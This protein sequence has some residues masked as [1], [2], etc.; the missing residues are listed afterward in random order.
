MDIGKKTPSSGKSENNGGVSNEGRTS[1]RHTIGG[2]P[3][4]N[5]IEP[6]GSGLAAQKSESDR[7]KEG[8]NREKWSDGF[9]KDIKATDAAITLFTGIMVFIACR[10][11]SISTEQNALVAASNRIS[12]EAA[13]AAKDAAL[14]AKQTYDFIKAGEVAT[15]EMLTATKKTAAATEAAANAT[16]ITAS[17]AQKS[18]DAA[19]AAADGTA[20]AVEEAKKSNATAKTSA[21]AAKAAAE[22]ATS[23][24]A[25]ITLAIDQARQSNAISKQGADAATLM[26]KWAAYATELQLRAYLTIDGATI[27][28]D[29]ITRRCEG[30][31]YVVNNGMT[32]AHKVRSEGHMTCIVPEEAVPTAATDG[33]RPN[34]PSVGPRAKY[35]IVIDI[36]W[37][38]G[39]RAEDLTCGISGRIDYEDMF[40]R[41]RFTE[42]S[43]EKGAQLPQR[44]PNE[45]EYEMIVNLAG[46]SQN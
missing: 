41:P 19:K 10:Q 33:S 6:V 30:V 40:R 35:K 13:Q 12:G 1:K 5:P 16:G 22:A 7:G 23:I 38:E 4:A 29:R 44:N 14:A 32:P 34:P 3:G 43:Y 21:D 37:D 46:N 15:N 31:V 27:T 20:A 18:A 26:A 28:F 17:A 25:S 42:F 9:L 45:I 8:Q 11:N 39:V 36:P 2:A 24:A